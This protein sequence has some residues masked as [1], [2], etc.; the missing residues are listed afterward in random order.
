MIGMVI[1]TLMRSSTGVAGQDYSVT[2][3]DCQYGGEA[4]NGVISAKLRKPQGFQGVPIFADDRAIDPE[5]SEVCSI[6]RSKEDATGLVYHL[7]VTDFSSCG[8]VLRN[9]FV[10]LRIWFPKLRHVVMMSDQEVIIMCKPPQ[11]VTLSTAGT[12]VDIFPSRSRVSGEVAAKSGPL[13]Y[14]VALYRE[15]DLANSKEDG[16]I[17]EAEAVP[18]GARLQL[19]ASIDTSSVWQHVRLQSV[20][21]SPDSSDPSA[22]GSVTL[23]RDGCRVEEFASIVPRQPWL[24]ENSSSEV[25]LEFEAVLLDVS[26]RGEGRLWVH[27]KSVA[28]TT[29]AE[30]RAAD[31]GGKKKRRSIGNDQPRSSMSRRGVG[32]D[33]SSGQSSISRSIG[34]SRS[35]YYNTGTEGRMV[36]T[37]LYVEEA[38]HLENLDDL[39][40]QPYLEEEE[41]VDYL[42]NLEELE[43]ARLSVEMEQATGFQDN[44]GVTVVMPGEDIRQAANNEVFRIYIE[45]K[46]MT[47]QTSI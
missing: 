9:G 31:C 6:Q 44:V 38:D 33:Q 34:G 41:E 4:G 32:I 20:I 2:D 46:A 11:S 37:Q 47:N 40:S 16:I 17:K 19:R 39:E 1:L 30:C 8:V 3:I 22:P 36:E 15:V 12:S 45:D 25:R 42:E 13:V 10:S 27:V 28:C 26:R 29:K 35:S 7:N 23:V 5:T 24:K 18:I 21:L 14:E 43:L